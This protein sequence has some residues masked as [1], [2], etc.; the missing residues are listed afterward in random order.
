MTTPEEAAY[1]ANVK[2]VPC[3]GCAGEIGVPPHWLA[4]TVACPKCGAIVSISEIERVLWRPPRGAVSMDGSEQHQPPLVP[5]AILPAAPVSSI[6]R[7]RDGV[8]E[9][10]QPDGLG[11]F[12]VLF[13]GGA[14]AIASTFVL[15]SSQDSP[16]IP[17]RETRTSPEPTA[18]KPINRVHGYV[19]L[20][21]GL[22]DMAPSSRLSREEAVALVEGLG[23]R[24]DQ[25]YR[26]DSPPVQKK[27]HV[28]SI[29]LDNAPF[30]GF[31]MWQLGAFPYVTSLSLN[32]CRLSGMGVQGISTLKR[33]KV[34]SMNKARFEAAN[35]AWLKYLPNLERLE[36]R[37][38]EIDDA[39]V[40]DLRAL[41]PNC[42]IIR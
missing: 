19:E 39:A 34:L 20:E 3:P 25:P 26:A 7:Q 32:G 13:S 15:L 10:R 22:Y 14:L 6:V 28:K 21:P 11:I 2:W 30:V 1:D 8:T 37:G 29:V 9:S 36:L 35:L 31:D 24:V 16:G 18:K 38:A 12:L 42:T 4:H 27:E 33:L 23:G 5:D 40:A 41:L 17:P